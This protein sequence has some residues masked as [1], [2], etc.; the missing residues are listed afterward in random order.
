MARLITAF[1]FLMLAPQPIFAQEIIDREFYRGYFSDPSIIV[2]NTFRPMKAGDLVKI[3]GPQNYRVHSLSNCIRSNRSTSPLRQKRTLAVKTTSQNIDWYES[4][5]ING[6]VLGLGGSYENTISRQDTATYS[7]SGNQSAFRAYASDLAIGLFDI[8]TV[9]DASKCP[10][11]LNWAGAT[12]GWVIPE[13]VYWFEGDLGVSSTITLKAQQEFSL[14]LDAI[15]PLVRQV[16]WA[17]AVLK[18]TSLSGKNVD[19]FS[20][21]TDMN[22]N[23]PGSDKDVEPTALA[24]RPLYINPEIASEI[25]RLFRKHLEENITDT[26]KVKAV[27]QELPELNTKSEGSLINR[28][29]APSDTIYREWISETNEQVERNRQIAYDVRR[30]LVMNYLLY[31]G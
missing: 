17:S 6:G 8:P 9:I 19:E 31:E 30:T 27:I 10:K 13:T 3:F 11:Y 15:A 24:L 22:A 26:E 21:T 29:F 1:I 16:P 18:S 12:G 7:G 5:T 2:L 20:F 14:S 4:F 28:V 23:F 25:S